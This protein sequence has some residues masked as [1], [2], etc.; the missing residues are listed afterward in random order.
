MVS[1]LD[2]TQQELVEARE[3]LVAL[4]ETVQAGNSEA[5]EHALQAAI[6]EKEQL[7]ADLRKTREEVQRLNER[8]AAQAEEL[9]SWRNKWSGDLGSMRHRLM[10]RAQGIKQTASSS[11]PSSPPRRASATSEPSPRMEPPPEAEKPA[12]PDAEADSVIGSVLAQL[13][14]LEDD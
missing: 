3:Q 10:E 2:S 6:Q 11:P 13:A 4:K 7:Q 8:V 14:D 9:A 12:P 5:N 1:L